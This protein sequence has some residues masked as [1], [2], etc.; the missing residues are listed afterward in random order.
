MSDSKGARTPDPLID[1]VREVRRK[2]SEQSDNDVEKLCE[3]LREV[4]EQYRSRIV[5]PAPRKTYTG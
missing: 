4:E 2:L 3:R 1:E 5:R